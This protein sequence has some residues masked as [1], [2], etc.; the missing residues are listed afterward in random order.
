MKWYLLLVCSVVSILRAQSADYSGNAV[1]VFCNNSVLAITSLSLL[2][3]SPYTYY[4]GNGVRR[5]SAT[6]EYGD[7]VAISMTLEVFADV[8]DDMTIYA[9]MGIYTDSER[10]YKSDSVDLC[11]AWVGR[12]CRSAG[13]YSFTKYTTFPYVAGGSTTTFIPLVE[14]GFSTEADGDFDLGGINIVCTENG[15]NYMEGASG[16]EGSIN[17]A[18]S[19]QA[20]TFGNNYGILLGTVVVVAFFAMILLHQKTEDKSGLLDPQTHELYALS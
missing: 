11:K 13:T 17:F 1:D 3:N 2:C 19:R 5:N 20:G 16:A 4:Y 12:S 7:R 15:D 14:I 10:L 8:D 18:Y 6:C 9:T